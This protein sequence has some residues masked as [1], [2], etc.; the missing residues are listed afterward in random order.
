MKEAK[1]ITISVPITV[2]II[3]ASNSCQYLGNNIAKK[4]SL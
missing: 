1:N 2:N 4:I 3:H